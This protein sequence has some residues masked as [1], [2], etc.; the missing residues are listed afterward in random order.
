MTDPTQALQTQ[1]ANIEKRAGRTLAQLHELLA[2]SGLDKHGEMVTMLKTELHMG[3]GDANTVVHTFRAVAAAP[4]AAAASADPLESIYAGSKA[5]L[6]LLHDAVMAKV[7][8]FGPFEIAPK[9]ANVSL[10]RKKQWAMLGPGSKGRLEIGLNMRGV[11]PTERLLAQ[12]EGGMCQYKVFVATAAEIDQELL[13]WLRTA[14]D[15]AG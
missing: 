3:H 1:L 6:R 9:K 2:K 10:R 8:E 14:F 15:A 12:P 5:P 11:A 4:T 13:A 7:A